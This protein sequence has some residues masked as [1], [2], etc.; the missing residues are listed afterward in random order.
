MPYWYCDCM[1]AGKEVDATFL[2]EHDLVSRK[3]LKC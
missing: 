3:T 2:M 1:V